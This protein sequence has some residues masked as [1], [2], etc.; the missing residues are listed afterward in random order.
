MP[1][2]TSIRF[3]RRLLRDA[4]ISRARLDGKRFVGRAVGGGAVFVGC[5]GG[6]GIPS[7]PSFFFAR[8]L[9]RDAVISRARL[10]GKRFVAR[11]R[12]AISIAGLPAPAISSRWSITGLN[13]D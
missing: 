10:D 7:P 4:V 11:S 3:S 6:R 2:C 12:R 13:T 5:G 1:Y 8:R 9:P